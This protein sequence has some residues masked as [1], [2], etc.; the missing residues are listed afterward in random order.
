MIDLVEVRKDI[1]N[2]YLGENLTRSD[3][4]YMDNTPKGKKIEHT[5]LDILIFEALK[6]VYNEYYQPL[7]L[8]NTS[9]KLIK[10]KEVIEKISDLSENQQAEKQQFIKS[11]NIDEEKIKLNILALVQNYFN[12]V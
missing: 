12:E 9:D 10:L 5:A 11:F 4:M 2:E 6:K 1:Y 7:E 8:F 3:L